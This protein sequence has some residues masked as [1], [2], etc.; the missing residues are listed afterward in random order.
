MSIGFTRA[1]ATRLVGQMVEIY[2]GNEHNSSIKDGLEERHKSII[3]GKLL[4]IDNECLIVLYTN[5]DNGK[6]NKV[7]INSWSVQTIISPANSISCA[8]IYS[9]DQD[10]RKI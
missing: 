8:D 6:E 10:R 7:Y 5:P 9:K 4:E 3:Y 2:Q 1:I